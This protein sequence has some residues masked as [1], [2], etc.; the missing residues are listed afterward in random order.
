MNRATNRATNRTSG[1]RIELRIELR[2]C[3]WSFRTSCEA[4]VVHSRATVRGRAHLRSAYAQLTHSR[5]KLSLASTAFPY[6]KR[7]KAG[8]GLGTRLA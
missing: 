8:R 3:E 6:C 7:R 5:D 1:L 2:T 4:N